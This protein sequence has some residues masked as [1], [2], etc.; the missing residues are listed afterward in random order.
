MERANQEIA[1]VEQTLADV[2]ELQVRELTDL[3]LAFVGGGAGE[4]VM[5]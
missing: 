1:A 3:Q 2:A 4:T 5:Q